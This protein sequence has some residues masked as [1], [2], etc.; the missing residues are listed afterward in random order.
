MQNRKK[1]NADQVWEWFKGLFGMQ[2]S[3]TVETIMEPTIKVSSTSTSKI[4]EEPEY[5]IKPV[6]LKEKHEKELLVETTTTEEV[7]VVF[8]QG[9][10]TDSE[11]T[12]IKMATI[13]KDPKSVDWES[14]SKELNRKIDSLKSKAKQY[15]K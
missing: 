15:I 3:S 10:F 12:T 6:T 14:L 1:E 11:I 8:K 7:E 9:K 13:G 2:E 4:V 5:K